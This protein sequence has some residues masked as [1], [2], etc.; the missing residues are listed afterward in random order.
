MV[1]A[2]NPEEIEQNPSDKDDTWCDL[3]K[4]T[5]KRLQK[6]GD[7]F[8]LPSREPCVRIPDS[9]IEK[10]K[11]SW[12]SFILGQFYS[13]PP[14]QGT[15]HSIVNGIWSKQFRDVTVSKMEGHAFLFA[16]QMCKLGIG[17]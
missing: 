9:V 11:K 2:A 7:A 15:I 10:H 6:K 14:S 16:S 5:S 4:V 8:T 17:C 3:F 13:D 12:E 1:V